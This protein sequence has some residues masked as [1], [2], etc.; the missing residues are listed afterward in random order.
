MNGCLRYCLLDSGAD[1]SLIP[2]QFIDSRDIVLCEQHLTA[3]NNTEIRIEGQ[4]QVKVKTDGQTIPSTLLVSPNVDEIILGRNWLSQN[5]VVW[6]FGANRV[7][8]NGKH[9]ELYD[10][11]KGTLRCKRCRIATDVDLPAN[12]EAIVPADL[13][14]G[15][16]QHKTTDEQWAT[17]PAEPIPG[18]RVARTLVPSD[19]ATVAVRVCNI[20][21]RPLKIS[22]GLQIGSLQ[23]VDVSSTPTA[24]SSHPPTGSEQRQ[25]IID[26]ADKSLSPPDSAARAPARRIP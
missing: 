9:C 2:S 13:V 25:S 8:I 21:R 19:R 20:T 15:H 11:P 16:F 3:A 17:V 5:S 24:P 18:L 22:K 4:V 14:Y 12:S 26:G 6:D 10:S 23:Q 7:S 1:A